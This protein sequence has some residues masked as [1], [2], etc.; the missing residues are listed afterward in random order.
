MV[1]VISKNHLLLEKHLGIS[2]L[3]VFDDPMIR[4]QRGGDLPE[5]S[6]LAK[7]FEAKGGVRSGNDVFAILEP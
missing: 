5:F 6:D 7:P 2:D 4:P 1:M 3:G